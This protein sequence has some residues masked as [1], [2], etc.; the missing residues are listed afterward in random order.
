MATFEGF[1]FELLR[2][3]ESSDGSSEYYDHA[4]PA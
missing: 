3:D 1:A 4:V 2:C